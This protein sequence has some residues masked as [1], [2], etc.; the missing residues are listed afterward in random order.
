MSRLFCAAPRS[1]ARGAVKER[2]KGRARLPPIP[3]R[4]APPLS[5]G[6]PNE[7]LLA[8]RTAARARASR[9]GAREKLW[10]RAGGW[11]TI[12]RW[13]ECRSLPRVTSWNHFHFHHRMTQGFRGKNSEAQIDIY[14]CAKP[15]SRSW[16]FCKLLKNRSESR[17]ACRSNLASSH[18]TWDSLHSSHL[19][20]GIR[21]AS[22]INSKSH[23]ALL[24]IF[25]CVLLMEVRIARTASS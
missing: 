23:S 15:E 24:G 10:E 4:P 22:G 7:S 3:G 21:S 8:V 9:S 18:A 16:F 17:L 19:Q 5:T 14:S 11:P 2:D 25:C 1:R 12:R 13:S 20:Q 6:A